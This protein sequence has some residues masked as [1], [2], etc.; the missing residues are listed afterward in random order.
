VGAQQQQTLVLIPP[1]AGHASLV[2]CNKKKLATDWSPA[3]SLEQLWIRARE[4]QDF[5][6][7]TG[8]P[9]PAPAE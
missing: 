3:A 6:A 2:T 9:I 1:H 8:E 5:A 4:C 7:I